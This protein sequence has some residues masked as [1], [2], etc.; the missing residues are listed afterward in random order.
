MYTAILNGF[1]G[2]EGALCTLVANLK[3]VAVGRM[4]F[5]AHYDK[6]TPHTKLG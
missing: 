5:R 2:S 1:S 3:C 4:K 6:E